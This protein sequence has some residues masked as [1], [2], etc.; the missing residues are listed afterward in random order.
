MEYIS[1]RFLNEAKQ[2][3]LLTYLETYEPDELVCLGKDNYCTR[4]HDSLKISNGMW[5]WWSRGFGGRSALDYLIKV[6]ELPLPDAVNRILGRAELP[7]PDKYVAP[8][9][10]KKSLHL[11]L[12][13][14]DNSRVKSYLLSRGID[15]N[16]VDFCIQSG[17][18][19][20]DLN[21]NNCIFLGMDENNV[22]KYAGYRATDE[23]R[24]LGDCEGSDKEYSFRLI[25]KP[26]GNTV[27]IFEGAIDLLSYA[28]L[29]NEHGLNFQNFNLLSLSGVYQPN[30][31]IEKSNV[32][33][34]LSK[35]LET[36]DKTRK[37][38]LHLDNDKVGRLAAKA[39]ITVLPKNYK[40]IYKP[41][42]RGKDVNDFLC[43]QKGI[44][45]QKTLKKKAPER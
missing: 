28:T 27:H 19:Y 32:P 40:V 42:E 12:K 21:H 23:R 33:V 11:P 25:G 1:P 10:E 9:R 4:T 31:V 38:V 3:D 2:M 34:A 13:S 6:K 29:I 16:V 37:I 17:I 35:Y 43:I 15:K 20:E 30:K 7:P 41:P 44:Y 39:L 36:H 26:D 24:F 8:K 5:M 22:P 14:I 18:L 45:V